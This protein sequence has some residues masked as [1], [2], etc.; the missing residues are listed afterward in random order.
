MTSSSMAPSSFASDVFISYAH[1]DNQP[2]VPGET[3]WVSSFHK[4]FQVLL[5]QLLGSEAR[6]WR[7]EKLQGNDIF[8]DALLDRMPETALLVS[9][10]SPRYVRSE[11]CNREVDAFFETFSK[12][13]GARVGNRSRILKV[14]KTQVPLDEQPPLMREMLGYEFFEVDDAGRPREFRQDPG[15]NKDRR[16]WDRL[17]DLAYDSAELLKELRAGEP[18]GGAAPRPDR[19]TV[20]L[21]PTTTD[22]SEEY[23]TI[24]RELQQRGLAVLPERP[25]PQTA[26]AVESQVREDLAESRLSVHLIG[27]RYGLV[28]EAGSKSLIDLQ[29]QL[30]A[31]QSQSRG[32]ERIIWMP[33]GLAP[34]EER[35]RQLVDRL[36][37]DTSAQLGAELLQTD[38][39]ELKTQIQKLLADGERTNGAAA[40]PAG[41]PKT[42]A[43]LYTEQDLE[44]VASLEDSLFDSGIEV[45]PPLLDGEEE[46]LLEELR[47]NVLMADAV[48]V[49]Y[50]RGD[51]RWFRRL[52]RELDQ[53]ASERDPPLAARAVYVG[54]PET[55]SKKRF[56]THKALVLRGGDEV[57]PAALAP[58][59][60]ALSEAGEGP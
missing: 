53:A 46:Q 24:R 26:E 23:A 22:L 29:N 42:V 40:P 27:R 47:E 18:V 41:G 35:Q 31:E 49:Y 33:V 39:G 15:A 45:A 30:A 5:S 21:A 54:P 44:D 8:G 43:T 56:K 19:G 10:L 25:L 60:A 36:E 58:L 55:A 52:S 37:T 9:I 3:G 38:L 20:Y 16:Y 7:D 2:L 51:E 12:T 32:L 13:G 14:V 11:W 17:A 28:P 59:L 4:S 50:G 6:V 1:I 34:E 48:L 57:D